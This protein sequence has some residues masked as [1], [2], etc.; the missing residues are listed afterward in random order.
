[1]TNSG[2]ASVTVSQISVAAPFAISGMSFPATV[3]VGQA[4]HVTL[5]FTPSASTDVS[6]QMTIVHTGKSSPSTITL[7]GHVTVPPAITL[8]VSPQTAGVTVGGT[9]QLTATVA[10]SANTAVTWSMVSGGGSISTSGLYQA[11]ASAT[12]AVVRATSAADNTKSATATITVSTAP[13]FLLSASPT[14]LA[15]G[16]L[17][18]GSS[19]T[20]TTTITNSGTGSV[21]INSAAISGAAF[22][23]S[24]I[25][26]PDTVASGGTRV[27]TVR[28]APTAAGAQTGSITLT[29]TASNSPTTISLTGTGVAPVG[30]LTANSTSLSFGTVNVGTSTTQTL[31][32]TAA[33]APVTISQ[34][35][36]TGAGFTV[37]GPTMPATVPAGQSASFSIQFSPT[38]SGAVNGSL[39][40][41]S[42][43]SNSP[44]TVSVSGTGATQQTSNGAPVLFFS[45]LTWGPKTGWEGS[46]TKGAA[47]TVWGKNFGTTRGTNFITVNGA[48]LTAATDYAEWDAIGP[49]RGLERI[50]FWLNSSAADGAG[51]ITITVNSQTSNSLP[52]TVSSGTIYFIAPTGNNANNGRYSSTQSGTNGPFKDLFM[53]NPGLDAYHGAGTRNPS[54]DG[55][56]IV[57]VRAGTYTVQDPAG[58]SAMIEL[59]GPYGG[60]TQQ[61]ALIGYPGETPIVNTAAATRGFV[62]TADYSP[63]GLNSYFTFAKLEGTNGTY[64]INVDGDWC[65][66]VGNNFH[67]Y[68]DDVWSGVVF[69]G[70]S[71][72]TS[73]FGNRFDHNGF[74]SF[75]HN[76]YIKTQPSFTGADI[77][78]LNT[79]VGW[80]EFSNAVA[81]D[82]H[83]GVIFISK[84]SDSGNYITDGT[85]IHDN[86]F[87]GGNVDF[88]YSG[89]NTPLGGTTTIF[90]NI[91]SGGTSTNGG[92]T[93]YAGTNTINLY[94]NVFYQIGDPT[95]PMV[96]GTGAAQIH[97]KN[98]IWYAQSAQ[99]FFT[100]ETFQG[101][102]ADFDHDLFYGPGNY[103]APTGAGMTQVG[104]ITGNPLLVNVAAGDFHVQAASP[105]VNHGSAAV[106]SVVTR[107]YDGASRPQGA[108]YDVGAYEQ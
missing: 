97:F 41:S 67:D 88:I 13:T 54:G 59:R 71:K 65:R 36:I 93:L 15:F 34:A 60:P 86:Y 39:T 14:S 2:S 40:I 58:D 98:N 46:T 23:M 48:Q 89:D 33:T 21:T 3:G 4:A 18:T 7:N 22:T 106:S 107:S 31:L 16:N 61:K 79:N 102:N 66:V 55:Q 38:A 83:G 69:V 37:T 24:G 17:N 11:P 32:V 80:N 43:A 1:V 81:S 104:A 50:T 5:S 70:G 92:L 100:L 78:T 82:T 85:L 64:A 47:V 68:L 84:S 42:N 90:N 91:F 9:V 28:F 62:W 8:T 87:H 103:A 25:T 73:I 12:T 77:S 72:N 35:A 95:Q 44:T 75:K 6:A 45:D 10:G 49:A 63:Y 29:S 96:W 94:N 30:T 56:Y 52:F 53:F 105:A 74:D 20:L 51:V 57:Y 99:P 27:I 76:V 108:G 19:A 101:A 26:T